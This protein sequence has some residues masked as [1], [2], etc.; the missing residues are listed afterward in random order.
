MI[1]FGYSFSCPGTGNTAGVALF[2]VPLLSWICVG[3]GMVASLLV[4]STPVW[5]DRLVS[6]IAPIQV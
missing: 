1:K 3:L 6:H 5:W 4:L 2:E